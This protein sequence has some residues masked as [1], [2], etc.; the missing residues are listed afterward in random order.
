[1]FGIGFSEII[2]IFLVIVVFIRPND[3]PK[4]LRTA[5][6][7]YGKAKKLYKEIIDAKDKV[8]KE[9]NEATNF[10]DI[11]ESAVKTLPKAITENEAKTP[12]ALPETESPPTKEKE[13]AAS[14]EKEPLFVDSPRQE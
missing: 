1:M 13:P 12:A 11:A 2:L 6:K 7:F 4:F 3:L 14:S 5:G 10:E 8:I 9:I